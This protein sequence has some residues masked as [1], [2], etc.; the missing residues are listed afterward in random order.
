MN[1]HELPTTANPRSNYKT[2]VAAIAVGTAFLMCLFPP[3]RTRLRT[4]KRDSHVVRIVIQGLRRETIDERQ[5][6]LA[7]GGTIFAT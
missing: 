2:Y 5:I 7:D 1:K 4:H 3:W 6:F